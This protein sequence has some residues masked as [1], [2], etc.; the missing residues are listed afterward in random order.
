MPQ[1]DADGQSLEDLTFEQE[2][3]E[4]ERSLQALK[5][6]YIQVQHDQQTQ[7]QLQQRQREIGQQMQRSPTPDLKAELTQ[8]QTRLEDLEVSLE[9][10]L[11]T[12]GSLKEPFWQIIRFGGLGLLLGWFLAFMVLHRPKPAPPPT[13]PT[14][15]MSPP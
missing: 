1:P 4:L 8:I 9:S 5:D 14:P 10:R 15:T 2:F 7:V 11:F 12:W 13:S 3:A 6:R